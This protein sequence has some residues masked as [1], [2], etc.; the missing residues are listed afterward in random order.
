MNT[1]RSSVAKSESTP[2]MPTLAK[3]AVN[4]AKHADNS[5]HSNQ[6]DG[7]VMASILLFRARPDP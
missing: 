3:I 6:P 4:A 7:N 2:R 5:A 1:V